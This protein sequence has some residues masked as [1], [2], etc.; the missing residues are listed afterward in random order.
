MN[1]KL[2]SLY[3]LKFNPF[4]PDVPPSALWIS[5]A[6]ENF[7][8]RL[9]QQVGEGGFS[10][11]TGESGS[12]K[13][14][15]LRLLSQKL[16]QLP[17]LSVG[18]LTRPQASLAD[19]YRELGHLFNVA[20]SPHNRWGSARVLR[21]KWLN[22]IHTSLTRPLLLIDEAQEMNPKVLA[23]LRLLASAELDARSILAVILAGDGRLLSR[24]EEPE[25]LPIAS[26]IRWRLPHPQLPPAQ[27]LDYLN[28]LMKS[29]GNPKLLP[30]A[31]ATTLSEHALGN[32][33]LLMN[34]ANELLTAACHKELDQIDEKLYFEVFASEPK[35][36]A[37]RS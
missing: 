28:H 14:S 26:R 3:D 30:P 16:G 9:E 4:A 12:G 32:L 19:F 18:V 11:I 10:L 31:L 37:K 35:A 23:E 21:E 25:L 6:F 29:A 27:L 20:L 2:L 1:K 5:P 7:S 15:S 33:R 22:H 13:S 24:L 17:E 34:L 36:K 8:W